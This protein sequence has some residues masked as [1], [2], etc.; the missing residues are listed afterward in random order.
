[1]SLQILRLP[2]FQLTPLI[3]YFTPLAKEHPQSAI[4][5]WIM[6]VWKL[7]MVVTDAELNEK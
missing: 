4:Y 5:I 3:Y 1:M 7:K 2:I 6:L